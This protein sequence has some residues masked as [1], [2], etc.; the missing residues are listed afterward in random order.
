VGISGLTCNTTYH[1]VVESIDQADNTATTNDATFRTAACPQGGPVSDDFHALSLNTNLWSAVDPLGDGS[2]TL[3]GTNAL[4]QVPAGSVHDSSASGNRMLR[5]VQPVTNGNFGIEVKFESAVTANAQRQGVL[6]EQDA[7][8]Y[9]RFGFL[10]NGTG[11]RIEATTFTNNAPTARVNKAI[12]TG[13]LR[14]TRTGSTWVLSWS[15]NGSSFT[16]ATSFTHAITANRAGPFA[17]N[18]GSPAPALTASV[19]YFFNS[20]SP[21]VPEDGGGPVDLTPPTISNVVA[22]PGS[23]SASF[24]WATDEPATTRVDAAIDSAY[25]MSAENPA[26]VTNHSIT[27]TGLTCATLYHYAVTSADAA[28]NST[29]SDDETFTTLPCATGAPVSDDF[30]GG[31]LDASLWSLV[32]PLGDGTVSFTPTNLVLSVP[33]GAATHDAAGTNGALRVMQ[34]VADT[35]FE[36]EAKFDSRPA[37]GTQREGIIVEQSAGT[38]LRFSFVHD[39][40]KLRVEAAS[41]AGGVVTSRANVAI[42]AGS[43]ALW[44]RVARSGGSWTLRWSSNGTSFTT[45]GTFTQALVVGAVGPFVGN[46]GSPAPAFAASIDHFFNTANPDPAPD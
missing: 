15:T 43:S 27:L 30:S 6:V 28:T 25:D 7:S 1:F 20:A 23:S 16:Q 39:G 9:I 38:Y 14:V 46:K 13:W 21:I 35:S 5:I 41:I 31:P 22:T 40:K 10:R 17:G 29:S 19:D 2:I 37:S 33:G 45:V 32:N 4:L 18:K 8:N 11:P 34:D 44:M 42:P 3:N 24:T 36:V 12:S 26:L